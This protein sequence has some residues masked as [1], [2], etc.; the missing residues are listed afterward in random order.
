M[1]IYIYI[2]LITTFV[3]VLTVL[4]DGPWWCTASASQQRIR[5]A[6]KHAEGMDPT[7]NKPSCFDSCLAK[8][9]SV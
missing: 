2:F 5:I 9:K 8:N 4:I 3:G 7:F 1:C 6:C